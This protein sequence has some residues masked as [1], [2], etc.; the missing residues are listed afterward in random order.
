MKKV[1]LCSFAVS[2]AAGAYLL[3]L[4]GTSEVSLL[5]ANVEALTSNEGEPRPGMA[6]EVFFSDLYY[7]YDYF[8]NDG[9]VYKIKYEATKMSCAG[10]EPIVPC[11]DG[12]G[13]K[14]YIGEPERVA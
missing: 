2:L 1:I 7:G 6:E 8:V 10:V 12:L 14:S 11:I 4:N 5:S 13:S 9:V 3:N